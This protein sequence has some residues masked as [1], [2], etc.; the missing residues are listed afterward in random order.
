L[1]ASDDNFVTVTAST[2]AIELQCKAAAAKEKTTAIKPSEWNR[3]LFTVKGQ[4]L[5]VAVNGKVV[6]DNL[7]FDQAP[8]K[9]AIVL[10]HTGQPMDFANLLIRPL[11]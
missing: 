8:A 5:T 1:R 10:V 2:D 7:K 6:I 11:K 9:G 4:H 3:S